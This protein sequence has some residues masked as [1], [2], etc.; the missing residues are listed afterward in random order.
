MPSSK[1][2]SSVI[3]K[4]QSVIEDTLR[5]CKHHNFYMNT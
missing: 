4:V 3:M 5:R 2:S 1:L